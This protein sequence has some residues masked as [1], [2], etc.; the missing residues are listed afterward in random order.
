MTAAQVAPRRSSRSP[1][2]PDQHGA[3]GFLAL[4]VALG[5]TAAGLSWSLVPLVVAWVAAYPFSWALTGRL[6]ARRPERFNR[7]LVVWGVLAAPAALLSVALRPW[8]VWIGLGYL[9]LYGVSLAFA[10][11]RNERA[12]A[13]DLVLVA[14]CSGMVAVVAGAV[15]GAD[16]W[17]LPRDAMLTAHVVVMTLV[18]ALTLVGSTLHVKS[19]IRERNNPA[20]ARA[21]T[22]F[23]VTS[24]PVV[25]VAAVAAELG[26]WLAFPF[27]LLAARA[28]WRQPTWRPAR[29]GLVELGCLL[30]VVGGAAFSV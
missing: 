10:R 2:V 28:I 25:A 24:M 17:M 13:N 23:A 19:L 7:A 21:S 15:S 14:Q 16:G 27:V 4:P 5:I 26:W 20:Y 29:I 18:C 11:Q 1:V 8:L 30:A 9:A 12:L 22:M 3:W 6:T